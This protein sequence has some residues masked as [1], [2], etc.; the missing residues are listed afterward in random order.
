MRRRMHAYRSSYEEEDTRSVTDI[1]AVTGK[2]VFIRS[3]RG[4]ERGVISEV[5]CV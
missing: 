3:Q 2:K 5:P 4:W 1:T